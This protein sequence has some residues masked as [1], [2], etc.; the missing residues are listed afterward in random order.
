MQIIYNNLPQSRSNTLADA[1]AEVSINTAGKVLST[2][3][4]TVSLDSS[5][6]TASDVNMLSDGPELEIIP[7]LVNLG[8]N[9]W[10]VRM[11]A[12]VGAGTEIDT[13]PGIC[14][15]VLAG[16][17]INMRAVTKP[18]SELKP[19]LPSWEE[20]ISFLDCWVC[21][22]RPAT[23]WNC[24]RLHTRTPSYHVWSTLSLLTLPQ[25]PNQA[26]PWP[27][28]LILPDFWRTPH[29]E[30]TGLRA[31]VVAPT[32]GDVIGNRQTHEQRDA[33]K[34]NIYSI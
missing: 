2:D 5:G 19:L 25:F 12:F 21:C 34:V 26:P 27:Q 17:D 32:A 15:E 24:R 7:I 33:K 9:W 4:T 30:H 14:V 8:M 22:C 10:T 6:G 31:F 3:F 28:Q 18:A 16:V 13:A 20:V 29:L 1:W 23:A 11:N